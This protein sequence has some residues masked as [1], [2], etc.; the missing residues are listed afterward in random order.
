M[1][2]GQDTL[3]Y[4]ELKRRIFRLTRLFLDAGLK[5]GDRLVL[6][7]RS[8]I[9]TVS[10]FL[11]LLVNGLTTVILDPE[12]PE[13]LARRL[14]QAADPKGLVI[15][16]SLKKEWQVNHFPWVLPVQRK[17]LRGPGLLKKFSMGSGQSELNPQAFPAILDSLEPMTP[18]EDIPGDLT[19]VIMFTSGSTSRP[20]G[21]ELTRDNLIHHMGTFSRQF[22]YGA[23]SRILNVLPL[24]H[25]DGLF[26]GPLITF[27]SGGTLYR[28]YPFSIPNIGP[29]L[30]RIYSERIT[31]FIAVPTMLRLILD[32]G[33]EFGENFA[34]ED[35]R[36][37]VSTADRLDEVLWNK[38]ESIFQVRV[39]NIYGLTETVAGALFSGPGDEDRCI[40]TVGRPVDCEA[41][42]VDEA[43]EDV[44]DE[45]VGELLL[46]GGNVMK[47]YFNDPESTAAA[48]W[49]EWLRTGDLA[50]RD[51]RG[52]YRIVGRKK[53][54]IITGGINVFPEEVTE[55][56]NLHPGVKE[57]HTFGI[58]DDIWG[59]LV[60]VAVVP[61]PG[62]NFEVRELI[63]FCRNHLL[64]AQIPHRIHL[65]QSL[66]K[67]PSGKVISERVR[68]MA[69]S[70]SEAEAV[71]GSGDLRSRIHHIATECFHVPL[72]AIG[73]QS[74]LENTPGWDSL[75]HFIFVARLEKA[76]DIH[77][78]PKE[79]MR[80]NSIQ[81]AEEIV[82]DQLQA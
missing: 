79:I 44:G 24:H 45:S 63:R 48:L 53:N 47:G 6:A 57:S 68:N 27:L 17:P 34:S 15:D 70:R 61:R 14:I 76:F 26:Q 81:R 67:G 51:P 25:A 46:R 62:I 64:P 69:R 5:P 56:I 40:G 8:A 13:H 2:D 16:A 71:P 72:S 38:F 20:K 28:P 74:S 12:S 10:V 19:A 36:F 60:A 58:S 22:D 4:G 77:L 66:P 23:D 80:I 42:I 52:Y 50:V 1:V 78:S 54:V 30:D 39:S 82:N 35:F 7:C 33:K 31:H 11:A 73:P 9:D 18:P 75:A 43:G 59:E 29:L 65:L 41:R 49:G 32:F 55:V 3:T 37:V 21:V